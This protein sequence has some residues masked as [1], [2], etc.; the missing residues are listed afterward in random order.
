MPGC[1]LDEKGTVRRRSATATGESVCVVAM[2]EENSG[3]AFY[4]LEDEIEPAV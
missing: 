2:D 4:S 1:R 3:F